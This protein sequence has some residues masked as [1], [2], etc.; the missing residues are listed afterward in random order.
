MMDFYSL[1][2]ILVPVDLSETSLNALDTAVSLAKKHKAALVIVNVTE[3]IFNTGDDLSSY[4]FST[5]AN[6]DVLTALTGGIHRNAD[7]RPRLI[8]LEGHVVECIITT[9][10]SEQCDLIV[11]GTHGASGF[12]EGFLGSNT[13]S[14]IK[15]STCPVLTIPPTNK[16]TSFKKVVFPVRPV[17]GALQKYN[18]AAELMA[19]NATLQVLGVSNNRVERETGVLDKLVEEIQD[20]LPPDK[21]KVYTS[22][23]T[24][25]SIADDILQYA[26]ASH[27][28]LVVLTSILDAITKPNFIG[29]HTQKLINCSKVPVLT[30]KKIGVAAFA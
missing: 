1:K 12:R 4:Q 30:I 15:Y 9:S 2:K 6:T 21:V 5:Q 26:Q 10:L 20:Q 16:Y 7:I 8:Q 17:T 14:V 13:Y 11:M 29:P 24:G 25:S 23:G 22:W 27:P 28:D 19:A 3:R 18:V